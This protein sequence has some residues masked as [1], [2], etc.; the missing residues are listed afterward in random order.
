MKAPTISHAALAIAA[1]RNGRRLIPEPG[2]CMRG[3]HAPGPMPAVFGV[4][5]KGI[6]RRPNDVLFFRSRGRVV[7]RAYDGSSHYAGF[8]RCEVA[9]IA[10]SLGVKLLANWRAFLAD[11]A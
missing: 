10:G 11:K 8:R 5:N 1:T 6:V 3:A 4:L 7:G 2:A 9:C